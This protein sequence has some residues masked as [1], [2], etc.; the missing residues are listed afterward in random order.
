MK[1]LE[2]M[3]V[4]ICCLFVSYLLI[5]PPEW[6]MYILLLFFEIMKIN[7][8]DIVCRCTKMGICFLFKKLLEGRRE[9]GEKKKKGGGK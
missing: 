4:I 6:P 7:V 8:N 3:V 9:V 5:H 2:K 1:K